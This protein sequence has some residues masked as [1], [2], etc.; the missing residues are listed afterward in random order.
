[1]AFQ[2]HCC[3]SANLPSDRWH[4]G[5]QHRVI[6]KYSSNKSWWT[7]KQVLFLIA[8]LLRISYSNTS[9]WHNPQAAMQDNNGQQ[10]ALSFRSIHFSLVHIGD[11]LCPV[12]S[13]YRC[14]T[15]GTLLGLD[16]HKRAKR[17]STPNRQHQLVYIW[18]LFSRQSCHFDYQVKLVYV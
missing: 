7:L 14:S 15:C 18:P 12:H 9:V 11:Y 10:C 6:T 8:N 3:H 4:S 16:C 17:S 5:Q 13:N 2:I 1:M